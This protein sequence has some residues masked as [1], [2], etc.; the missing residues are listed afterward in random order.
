MAQEYMTVQ[1]F[2]ELVGTS[3]QNIYAQLKGRLEPY[4]VTVNGRLH[5]LKTAADVYYSDTPQPM[6]LTPSQQAH[7]STVN[8][9]QQPQSTDLN[10]NQS[11][12]N[13]SQPQTNT[14]NCE[15]ESLKEIIEVLKQELAAK[16]KQITELHT[17]LSQQQQLHLATQSQY[18]HLLET[19]QE[20]E[21]ES[22]AEPPQKKSFFDFF[23]K[24]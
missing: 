16:D 9:N 14:V 24:K 3:K 18:K 8:S 1:D 5:I 22:G 2:A 19:Q 7:S 13:S 11:Q 12:D 23:K 4:A 21:E 20:Q 6:P 10:S 15:N 17:L